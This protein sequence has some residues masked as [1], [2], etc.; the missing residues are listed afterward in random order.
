[1]ETEIGN[2]D[3]KKNGE[4][5][6]SKLLKEMR[7]IVSEPLAEVWNSELIRSSLR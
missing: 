7:H 6:P 3:P 5:V 4:C 1:M 2:L